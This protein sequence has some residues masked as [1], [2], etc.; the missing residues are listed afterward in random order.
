MMLFE[1]IKLDSF[2][3]PREQTLARIKKYF[4]GENKK[5]ANPNFD[6]EFYDVQGKEKVNIMCGRFQPLHLG[7]IS[8]AEQMYNENGLRTFIFS[9][10]G[11]ANISEKTIFSSELTTKSLNLVIENRPNLFCGTSEIPTIMLDTFV[12]PRLRPEFEP[13]LFGAGDDRV[14]DYESLIKKI[15]PQWNINPDFKV[16]PLVRSGGFIQNISATKVRES[17][18]NEDFETFSSY[19]PKEIHSLWEEFVTESKNYKQK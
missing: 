1:N 12:I 15:K 18:F 9:V 3:T 4:S 17:I 16:F 13:V 10:R 11:K 6:P 8:I 5:Y 7:H 19:C 2:L 14:S